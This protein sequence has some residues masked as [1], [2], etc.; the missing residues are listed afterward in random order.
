MAEDE[1]RVSLAQHALDEQPIDDV[2][3]RPQVVECA[4]RGA[5]DDERAG[6]AVDA[7][8]APVH[9][10]DGVRH[11]VD[12][13]S[14]RQSGVCE[15]GG[16]VLEAPQRVVLLAPA[17]LERR[18]EELVEPRHDGQRALHVAGVLE[19]QLARVVPQPNTSCNPTAGTGLSH[20][21]LDSKHNNL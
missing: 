17:V 1:H 15:G 18:K 12:K 13:F 3:H 6:V 2:T 4:D 16:R 5:V 20:A 7:N 9:R 19:A 8:D 11:G 21:L 10:L 14:E